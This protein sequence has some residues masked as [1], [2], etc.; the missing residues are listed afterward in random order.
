MICN[1]KSESITID[2]ISWLE[3]KTVVIIII[4]SCCLLCCGLSQLESENLQM[5]K[6]IGV[7][8]AEI[9]TLLTDIGQMKENAL[10]LQTQLELEGKVKEQLQAEIKAKQNDH[11]QHIDQFKVKTCYFLSMYYYLNSFNCPTSIVSY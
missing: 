5:S 1:P 4:M 6:Q 3:I 7:T 2:L 8:A 9:S 10:L 11:D